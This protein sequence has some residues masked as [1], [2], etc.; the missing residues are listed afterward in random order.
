MNIV[1]TLR[2]LWKGP[3]L[4]NCCFRAVFM[5]LVSL[6]VHRAPVLASQFQYGAEPYLN[7]KIKNRIKKKLHLKKNPISILMGQ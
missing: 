7:K 6:V 4:E 2:E 3:C 5:V 1:L